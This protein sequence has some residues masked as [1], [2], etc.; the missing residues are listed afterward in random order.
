[1]SVLVQDYATNRLCVG[2][3]P[4]LVDAKATSSLKTTVL[5]V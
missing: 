4:T 2:Y 3:R 1:M 5:I